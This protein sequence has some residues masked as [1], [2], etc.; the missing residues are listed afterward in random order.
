[1]TELYM[2]ASHSNQGIVLLHDLLDQ[3]TNLTSQ[4][5]SLFSSVPGV[6]KHLSYLMHIPTQVLLEGSTRVLICNMST[7][8]HRTAKAAAA[9]N[10]PCNHEVKAFIQMCA[11]L[12]LCINKSVSSLPLPSVSVKVPSVSER[13]PGLTVHGRVHP[14]V[15]DYLTVFPAIMYECSPK[16]IDIVPPFD[17]I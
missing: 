1:M 11:Q 15:F 13:S 5:V 6:H 9:S 7:V 12:E 8:R 4:E 10:L 17:L 14:C 2:Y 3:P 16:S